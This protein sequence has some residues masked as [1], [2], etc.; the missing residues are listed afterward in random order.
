M[1]MVAI[2]PDEVPSGNPWPG[3]WANYKSIDQ[4]VILVLG[5]V[6]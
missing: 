3:G 1:R 4:S 2:G 5:A 6:W